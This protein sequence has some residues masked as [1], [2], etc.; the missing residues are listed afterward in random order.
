MIGFFGARLDY[1]NDGSRSD[2]PRQVVNVAVRVVAN[3]TPS[4]PHDVANPEI[5]CEDPLDAQAVEPG[6]AG[7]GFAEQAFLGDEQCA[8]SVNVDGAPFHHDADARPPFSTRGTQLFRPSQ[9][10][11]LRG[12]RSSRS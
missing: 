10:A 1:G 5:V 3:N 4:Q 11:I 7:L 6:V 12:R 9:R 8:A 2:K